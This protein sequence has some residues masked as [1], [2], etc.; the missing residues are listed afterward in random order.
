[1]QPK[2]IIVEKDP[3][4]AETIS[5]LL[6]QLNFEPIHYY[7]WSYKIKTHPRDQVA[8]I[9]VNIQ[10]LTIKPE[11][12]FK[13]LQSQPGRSDKKIAL[14]FIYKPGISDNY[15]KFLQLPH[16]AELKIP[17]QLEDLYTV[18]RGIV[19]VEP[20]KGGVTNLEDKLDIINQFNAEFSEWLE[21]LS[22]LVDKK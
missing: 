19:Q 12:I 3:K 2:I 5:S 9:I 17:F 13:T 1:M 6:E 20:I 10:I 11:E 4:Q 7:N 22:K 8:A 21:Q 14:L 15:K 18:L 16:A